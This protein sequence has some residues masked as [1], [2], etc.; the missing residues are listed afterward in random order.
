MTTET[1]RAG[2]FSRLLG[3]LDT[4]RRLVLNALFLLLFVML[5]VGLFSGPAEPGIESGTVLVVAPSGTIV[6][7][8]RTPELTTELLGLGDSPSETELS[9]IIDALGAAA[10]DERIEGVLLDFNEMGGISPGM[11]EAFAAALARFRA[12]GKPVMA[13][14]DFYTQADY[15][16]ASQANEIYLD[17]FGQVLVTGYGSYQ[18]YMG[19]A[20]ERYG[21]NVRVY[22]AGT[23][24]AATEPFSRGSMSDASR[25]AQAALVEQF[26]SR[27]VDRVAASRGIEHSVLTEL[28]ND[29]A[30]VYAAF[31]GDTAI[32]ALEAGL[33]DELIETDQIE[34]RVRETFGVAAVD[35]AADGSPEGFVSVDFRD[36]VG[37]VRA[38][39]EPASQTV[40]LLHAEGTILD[41]DQPRGAIGAENLTARIRRAREDASTRALV[42]R[43]NS[44]GGSAFASERIRR[45]LELTQNAGKPVVISMSGVAASGGYWIAATADQIWASPTTITGSIGVFAAFPTFETALEQI[46]ARVDGVGTGP[47]A[48]PLSPL[49][50]VD[51]AAEALLQQSVENIY[52]RFLARVASGREMAREAVDEV[53]QGRVWTG[54]DA[55]RL[56]LVD[57]LGT[58]PEAVAA[59]ASLAEL[60][61]WT[62]ERFDRPLTPQEQ[63]AEQLAPW[64]AGVRATLGRDAATRFSDWLATA[65]SGS[66]W[67]AWVAQDPIAGRF[68][69]LAGELRDAIVTLRRGDALA[70]CEACALGR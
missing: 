69:R 31:D 62:V 32:A 65:G 36:Y 70:F 10:S 21:V 50:E 23:Y 58:L 19:D 4:F 17:P 55:H 67:G 1:A 68:I 53:G 56:G 18:L 37:I 43:V 63:F 29:P 61:A 15:L 47:M 14:S 2:L 28:A 44:P 24:K 66:A 38:E 16:I 52:S 40:A 39:S 51:P 60:D 20:L 54:A 57:A 13:V 48:R 59:A 64:L 35:V 8:A 27:Y 12:S 42:L 34:T 45:E 22:R 9:T 33:V 5:L 25:E 11:A 26:W 49:A 30:A 46:D 6:E 3:W 7:E 41:G